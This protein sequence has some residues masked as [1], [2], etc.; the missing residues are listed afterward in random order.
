MSGLS[1]KLVSDYFD[2]AIPDRITAERANR[3]L[4]RDWKFRLLEL[5]FLYTSRYFKY[6]NSKVA[7]RLHGQPLGLSGLLEDSDHNLTLLRDVLDVFKTHPFAFGRIVKND[8]HPDLDNKTLNNPDRKANCLLDKLLAEKRIALGI[9]SDSTLRDNLAYYC[10]S[11]GAVPEGWITNNIHKYHPSG[12]TWPLALQFQLHGYSL[13]LLRYKTQAAIRLMNGEPSLLAATNPRGPLHFYLNHP[14]HPLL[15]IKPTPMIKQM[16]INGEIDLGLKDRF[17]NNYCHLIAFTNNDATLLSIAKDN[18]AAIALLNEQ[19]DDGLTPMHALMEYQANFKT[20]ST[21]LAE[22]LALGMNPT[23]KTHR[24]HDALSHFCYSCEKLETTIKLGQIEPLSAQLQLLV[25]HGAELTHL[26]STFFKVANLGKVI[27]RLTER[28]PEATLAT[29]TPVTITERPLIPKRSIEI[30]MDG[31]QTLISILND[32]STNNFESFVSRDYHSLTPEN[33]QALLT[34]LINHSA[35]HTDTSRKQVLYMAHLISQGIKLN[36]I[37]P[38]GFL[39]EIKTDSYNFILITDE[40]IRQ[41]KLIKAFLTEAHESGHLVK[42]FQ[43]IT[44][45]IAYDIGKLCDLILDPGK[46]PAEIYRDYHQLN[47]L[48]QSRFTQLTDPQSAIS[49]ETRSEKRHA[50]NQ[51]FRMVIKQDLDNPEWKP[52]A[53]ACE[54]QLCKG[55]SLTDKTIPTALTV[56]PSAP[57]TTASMRSA[58]A[59]GAGA[60]AGSA[61]PGTERSEEALCVYQTPQ[62]LDHTELL[63]AVSGELASNP[64]FALEL[65]GLITSSVDP[66]ALTETLKMIHECTGAM[67]GKDKSPALEE[68]PCAPES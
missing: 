33:H 16:F 65:M 38:T 2:G 23:I 46:S 3:N 62:K 21:S 49:K 34:H 14:F 45:S 15:T 39:K 19:N 29:P 52:H 32:I 55:S 61:P 51:L 25:N 68:D 27:A 40:M 17:N 8:G 31:V 67:L 9:D 30:D 24:G 58:W 66:A 6:S 59:D 44:N 18:P 20:A 56:I 41:T 42:R 53:L 37:D 10:Q 64:G 57:P 50:L 13:Y 28:D 36:C 47:H 4:P 54:L 48:L 12:K 63:Q 5:C 22:L 60:G 26:K 7:K 11:I 43:F 35:E 1:K